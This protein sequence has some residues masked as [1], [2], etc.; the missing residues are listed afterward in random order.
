MQQQMQ[1][2]MQQH[3]QRQQRQHRRQENSIYIG[4]IVLFPYCVVRPYL[5]NS[6]IKRGFKSGNVI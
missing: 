6:C 3:Q 4:D 2:Q 5:K 1:Q